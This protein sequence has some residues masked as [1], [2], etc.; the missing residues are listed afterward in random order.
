MAGAA[1]LVSGCAVSQKKVVKPSEA[2]AP[3]LTATKAELIERFNKQ[4]KAIDSINASVS[5]KVTAGS[6]YS[7]VIEEYHEINAFILASRPS[8][9]R[10]IGQ[11]PVVGKNIFDMVSD[12]QT[13]HIFIPSK[14]KFIEGPAKL[15]RPAKKPVENLR[16]QHILDALFWEPIPPGHVVL[17]EEAE[18]CGS[19]SYVLTFLGMAGTL[20]GAGSHISLSA[21]ERKIWFNRTDL[22]IS[23]IEIFGAAEEGKV[24]SDVHYN[25]WDTTGATPYPRQI[26]LVR[27]EDDYKLDITVKKMTLNEP[28]SAEKFVLAQPPGT[29]LVRVGEDTPK[30]Q[31]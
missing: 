10:V 27:P 15:E 16:P 6:A 3:L 7:G 20:S 31:P 21:M 17:I 26:T 4:A 5:M 18:E 2:P 22:N 8:N 1:A 14:H 23:H 30:E 28:I 12:G 11:A 9:I 19:H 29:E 25:D 24:T 13:F